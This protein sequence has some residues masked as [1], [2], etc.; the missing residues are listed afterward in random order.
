MN[1]TSATGG[2]LEGTPGKSQEEIE[3][4]LHDLVCGITGMDKKLVRPRWQPEPPT[5]PGKQVDWCAFGITSKE[6]YN[7]P[8]QI[9]NSEGEGKTTLI[10][11]GKINVLA[12]FYGP[13]AKVLAEKLRNGL[14]VA[15]NRHFLKKN[16]MNFL[17]AGAIQSVP[18]NVQYSWR[19]REDLPLIFSFEDR[20]DFAILNLGSAQGFIDTEKRKTPICV[21]ET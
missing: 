14:H 5:Q 1:N 18:E 15:Q 8:A 6:P 17:V 16:R 9:H 13:G 3:N 11:H 20:S 12:S 2:L 7:F 21:E 19:A 10:T 4:I